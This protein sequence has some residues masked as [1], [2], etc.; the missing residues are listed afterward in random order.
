MK[1]S[2]VCVIA[3]AM[4][5]SAFSQ[6]SMPAAPTLTAGAEFKG[7]RFDWDA[8]PGATR[9]Q[10]EYRAHQ[11]GDFIQQGDDFPATAT[12]THFSF[13]LHL[14]DW[15]YARYRLAACNTAGCSRSTEVSVSDLRRDAVGYFKSPQP[16]AN[17]KFGDSADLSLD[18]YNLVVAAPNEPQGPPPPNPQPLDRTH[19]GSVYVLHRNSN[20]VWEQRTR[21]DVGADSL[22]ESG[23]KLTVA[24]SGSGN[25]VAVGMPNSTPDPGLA[26]NGE[27]SVWHFGNGHW[28]ETVIPK[29]FVN[30]FGKSVA[31]SDSGYTL[32]VG[33]NDPDISLTIYKSINGVWQRVRDFSQTEAGYDEKCDLPR[34][35]RD[36]FVVA[37]ICTDPGS[38]TRPA[39]QYVRVHSGTNWS[40]TTHLNLGGLGPA[41]TEWHHTGFALDRTGTNMAVQYWRDVNHDGTGEAWIQVIRRQY[42]SFD[43]VAQLY[44]GQWRNGAYRY[45]FGSSIAISGDGQTISVGDPADNGT[46]WGPRAAPLVAGTAQTGA[47]YVYRF[48]NGKWTLANTVKPNYSPNPG[49]A[50]IFGEN[51]T[52]SGTG[53]TLI[54]PVSR[55]SSSASGIGGDW[56][57]TGRTASGALFMY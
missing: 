39:T 28:V 25:T 3:L 42:P 57:N 36:G 26:T 46:S 33:L 41:G 18:G 5:V 49:T 13:P 4:S 53:K 17:G 6:T 1:T 15:T 55:E 14:F 19:G 43:D 52:L 40:V 24:T 44:P 29:L 11:T 8:V 27:V 34:L 54:I 38:D 48:S 7:L 35:S 37:E 50:H 23:I 16:L 47:V 51:S 56:A 10:L 32:A 21:L 31:L 20:G 22:A 9:Y 2:T 30:S 12:S 45:L